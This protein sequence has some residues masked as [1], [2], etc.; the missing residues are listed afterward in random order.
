MP[1][2]MTM[3]HRTHAA[4]TKTQGIPCCTGSG[5]ADPPRLSVVGILC[6]HATCSYRLSL[7][8]PCRT[9]PTCGASAAPSARS[10]TLRHC[11]ALHCT[12]RRAEARRGE[13]RSGGGR[14]RTSATRARGSGQSA[15]QSEG[16]SQSSS[17]SV[18]RSWRRPWP[19]IH[20]LFKVGSI[21]QATRGRRKRAAAQAN[22]PR[23][24]DRYSAIAAVPRNDVSLVL[25]T[26]LATARLG[27]AQG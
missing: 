16:M 17:R 25:T 4:C 10:T 13:A 7:S 5:S 19:S 1:H 2:E 22:E 18:A 24:A 11:T 15:E 9:L 26:L 27:S 12:V 23:S 8:S 20:R 6:G 21:G 3:P 14:R